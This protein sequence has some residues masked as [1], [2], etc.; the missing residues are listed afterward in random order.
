MLLYL[1]GCNRYKPL[2]FSKFSRILWEQE[3]WLLEW[4]Q[5]MYFILLL[6]LFRKKRKQ[7][8]GSQTGL[9]KLTYEFVLCSQWIYFHM[10]FQYSSSCPAVKAIT[11]FFK[12]K[13]KNISLCF[14]IFQGLCKKAH[15]YN[16]SLWLRL[17]NSN[18]LELLFRSY[19]VVPHFHL[20]VGIGLILSCLFLSTRC[21]GL[22]KSL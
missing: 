7:I 12:E 16:F 14:P 6:L 10:K 20:F 13:K 19:L 4:S 21:W 3:Y 11:A 9:P 5:H 8:K 15:H 2:L 1:S 17:L 18:K 22:V